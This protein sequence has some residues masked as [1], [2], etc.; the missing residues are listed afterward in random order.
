M[1][2]VRVSETNDQSGRRHPESVPL[3]LRAQAVPEK[4]ARHPPPLV[5][6]LPSDYHQQLPGRCVVAVVVRSNVPR[7]RLR[8][9]RK[10]RRDADIVRP[11]VIINNIFLR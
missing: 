9:S 2:T 3:L 7:R 11:Q 6:R 8:T 10:S 5:G 4:R 1:T